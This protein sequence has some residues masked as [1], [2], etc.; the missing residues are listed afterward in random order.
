MWR[1]SDKPRGAPAVLYLSSRRVRATSIDPL[2]G[3]LFD[4]A[5]GDS[6]WRLRISLLQCGGFGCQPRHRPVDCAGHR[7]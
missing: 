6:Q 7:V 5:C 3:L 4:D 2:C 1:Y